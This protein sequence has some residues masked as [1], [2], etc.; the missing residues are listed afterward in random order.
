MANVVVLVSS[1]DGGILAT[2]VEEYIAQT[3]GK[4]TEPL[5]KFWAACESNLGL[6]G[7]GTLKQV[8][9]LSTPPISATLSVFVQG[10]SYSI[11]EQ[12]EQLA[13]LLAAFQ[14]SE[15]QE[16]VFSRPSVVKKDSGIWEIRAESTP[17]A[18]AHA[19]GLS[20]LEKLGWLDRHD[21]V[22]ESRVP[23]VVDGASAVANHQATNANPGVQG[24]APSLPP[25]L[26]GGDQFGNAGVAD[27]SHGG[28]ALTFPPPTLQG[29]DHSSNTGA[30]D[31]IHGAQ[32]PLSSFQFPLPQEGDHLDNFD[33]FLNNG[34]LAA[35]DQGLLPFNY[36]FDIDLA[37]FPDFGPTSP[38]VHPLSHQPPDYSNGPSPHLAPIQTALLRG[39]PG[40]PGGGLTGLLPGVADPS[41]LRG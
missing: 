37:D 4:D 40:Q 38:A 12:G 2:R 39:G 6:S 32:N 1:P 27:A 26:R 33:T 15:D 16:P 11:A 5:K 34:T 30:A 3:W 28:Q 21:S 36:S 18:A 24:I 10:I 7:T 9:E 17:G 20:A 25:T 35:P 14:D 19:G 23:S 29:V 41:A 22:D 31:A 8:D 13:W